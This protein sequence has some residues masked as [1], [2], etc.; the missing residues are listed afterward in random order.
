M[1]MFG[2]GL[3]TMSDWGGRACFSVKVQASPVVIFFPLGKGL[4]GGVYQSSCYPWSSKFLSSPR[5]FWGICPISFFLTMLLI[6]SKNPPFA[7]QHSPHVSSS[8]ATSQ[9]W[10]LKARQGFN[11]QPAKRSWYWVAACR[12]SRTCLYPQ[13]RPWSPCVVPENN[14]VWNHKAADMKT[15]LWSELGWKSGAC[16]GEPHFVYDWFSLGCF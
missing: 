15:G 6:C 3:Q 4:T 8:A 1:W 14:W 16:P 12:C 11:I 9:L 7:F 10:S 5:A 2:I 13:T